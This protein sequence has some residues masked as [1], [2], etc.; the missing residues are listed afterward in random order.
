[1]L[2]SMI[3]ETVKM[4]NMETNQPTWKKEIYYITN[5]T[6]YTMKQCRIFGWWKY[7]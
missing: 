2:Y 4:S 7:L 3:L 1:M 5:D 6:S